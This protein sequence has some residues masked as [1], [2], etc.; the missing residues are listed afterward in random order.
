MKALARQE[1]EVFDFPTYELEAR[2]AFE[3]LLTQARALGRLTG[4]IGIATFKDEKGRN[5]SHHVSF[6]DD[7]LPVLGA[8]SV[9]QTRIGLRCEA[10]Y[11]RELATCG[12]ELPPA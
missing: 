7:T 11:V 12:E 4:F 9:L 6:W 1:P 8:L 2:K 3:E 10:A 5:G